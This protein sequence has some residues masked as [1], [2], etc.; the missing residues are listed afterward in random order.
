M[1]DCIAT[2]YLRCQYARVTTG[3]RRGGLMMNKI[4][5]ESDI[6]STEH[7]KEIFDQSLAVLCETK[8]VSPRS[9]PLHI[10]AA[11]LQK[12]AL[13]DAAKALTMLWKISEPRRVRP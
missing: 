2:W 12:R 4:A 11:D 9:L 7:L 10:R 6:D 3:T 1:I 8:E 13:T 5:V